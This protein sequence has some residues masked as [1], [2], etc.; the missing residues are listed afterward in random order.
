MD[1]DKQ[2]QNLGGPINYSAKWEELNTRGVCQV[3]DQRPPAHPKPVEA[4]PQEASQKV[5]GGWA[6][7]AK[8]FL[9]RLRAQIFTGVL[10]EDC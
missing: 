9:N 1:I 5:G 10:Q 4:D 2:V 6:G 3:R 8:V 7:E